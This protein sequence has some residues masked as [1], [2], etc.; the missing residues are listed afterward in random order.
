[1]RLTKD[2]IR[3]LLELTQLEQVAEFDGYK[4]MKPGFGYAKD[5]ALGALQA[6]L[7]MMLEAARC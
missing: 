1:M 5:P 6:T 7:S 3:K 4:V 2:Q